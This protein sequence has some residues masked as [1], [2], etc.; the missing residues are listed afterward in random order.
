M[1][2]KTT[3]V[4]KELKSLTVLYSELETM[5]DIRGCYNHFLTSYESSKMPIANAQV[6]LN[7]AILNKEI[8]LLH[9][10]IDEAKAG[11]V[12]EIKGTIRER[13]VASPEQ[14][15]AIMLFNKDKRFTIT[16]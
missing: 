4:K 1:Q 6:Q 15:E 3:E 13:H 5:Q 16:E 9:L 7:K 10:D 12:E 11:V 8:N 2:T 14:M